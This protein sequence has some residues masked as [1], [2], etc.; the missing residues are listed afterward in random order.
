MRY[1]HYPDN[2]LTDV[3]PHLCRY[4]LAEG[5]RLVKT[6]I[7]A[8]YSVLILSDPRTEASTE[9]EVAH[10]LHAAA[11]TMRTWKAIVDTLRAEAVDASTLL[12]IA[13]T[14][15][16]SAP[17]SPPHAEPSD[18]EDLSTALAALPPN[19]GDVLHPATYCIRTWEI[20]GEARVNQPGRVGAAPR[21]GA[22]CPAPCPGPRH[23][24]GPERAPAH[25][26]T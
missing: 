23:R 17:P 18:V 6:T 19:L 2:F 14:P 24:S 1:P 12:D 26:R 16:A 22:A 15:P 5:K 4:I 25:Q 7:H 20:Y 21:P 11:R 9:A 10:K 3:Q 13:A 8:V